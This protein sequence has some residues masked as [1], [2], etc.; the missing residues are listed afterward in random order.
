MSAAP[1]LEP[2]RQALADGD[3]ETALQLCRKALAAA[4]E[5]ATVRYLGA[6]ALRDMNLLQRAEQWY[7]HALDLDARFSSAASGLASVLFDQLDMLGAAG[8]AAYAIRADDGN[9]EA[10][11]VRAMVRERRGDFEGAQ[12]DYRRA[13]QLDPEQFPLPIPLDDSTVDAALQEVFALL[14]PALQQHLDQIAFVLEEV[15][16]LEICGDFDPPAP[17]G[18]ILGLFSGPGFADERGTTTWNALPP[19]ILLFRRNLQRI[20]WDRE[21]LISELRV[22]L[23]HEIGHFLGLD[24]DDLDE[25]GLG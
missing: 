7:R 1:D 20:A 5:D 24:E 19:S 10:Y 4:P 25:R 8:A 6:E 15:P 21:H 9:P 14:P 17:P 2:A 16:S 18:E 22:T 11:Y 13:M 12:R 3:P 23:F